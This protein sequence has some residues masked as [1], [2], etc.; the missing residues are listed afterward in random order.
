MGRDRSLG[1]QLWR[2]PLLTEGADQRCSEPVSVGPR[3]SQPGIVNGEL[4]HRGPRRGRQSPH[5]E[6]R[7]WRCARGRE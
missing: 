4:G 6:L 2:R 5:A 1:R 3:R 7:V